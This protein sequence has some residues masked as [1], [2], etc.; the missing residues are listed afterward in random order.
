VRRPTAP[1]DICLVVPPFDTTR[2]P[3]LGP[4]V[5]LAE[6][7]ARG[8]NA[9]LLH[10]SL[11]LAARIG[12]KANDLICK[13]LMH[14][15]V[16][17]R[18]FRDH[19]F[20]AGTAFDPA[21]PLGRRG[22]ALFDAAA[23]AI[24]PFVE[25]MTRRILRTRPRI[26]GFAT[27]FQQNLAAFALARRVKERAPDVIVCVGG[28][29]VSEP[30][31]SGLAKLFGFVDHFFS[32]EADLVFPDFCQ[33]VLAGDRAAPRIVDCPPIEDMAA[34]HAPDYSD[35]FRDLRRFQ[36]RG[37][38]PPEIPDF[39]AM[40]SSRGCWWGEKS[41]CTFC[42]LNGEGMAFRSKPAERVLGEIRGHVGRWNVGSL[43]MT[44][45]IMPADFFRT[46]L[47]QLASWREAPTLFWEIKSNMRDEQVAALAAAGVLEIQ[48][49]IESLSS[50]VLKLMR[51]G[52]SAQQ[53]LMLM[54]A[55]MVHGIRIIWNLLYGLPGE[56][57]ADYRAMSAILPKLVHLP[58]PNGLS[59]VVIDR[60]SP[61]FDRHRDYGIAEIEPHPSYRGLYPA[62][63]PVAEIAYHF[64]G[65][66][67]TE[68]LDDPDL[69]ATI[70]S[71]VETWRE[72]WRDPERRPRLEMVD[73]GQTGLLTDSRFARVQ[74]YALPAAAVSALRYFER[75][76]AQEGHPA[77]IAAE[78]PGLLARDL[79]LLYEEKLCSIVVRRDATS[80]VVAL[81]GAD[82]VNKTL[83]DA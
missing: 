61:Y 26:V 7:R 8:L 79:L 23:P 2:F 47:P 80:G 48:P 65:R 57:T 37:L 30:M 32:G 45:N 3:P 36:A 9:T 46:L 20:A 53:N 17:E 16:G 44:D 75:P 25:A 77:V 6:L 38:L 35:Y 55:C 50:P 21:P 66:Y 67:S 14:G 31:A 1:T 33:R 69:I 28:A 83:A 39:L 78:I 41:H 52:V 74:A 51:K 12:P 13:G 82:R 42:G 5:L 27:S 59:P 58:P 43:G 68:L 54:R 19:A 62:G 63:A 64:G 40:E 70:R 29:N 49:G 15:L 22:R 72:R 18:L 76:R 34:V 60:Y 81:S 4:S 71:L 56:R 10:G 24:G 73:A 11:M